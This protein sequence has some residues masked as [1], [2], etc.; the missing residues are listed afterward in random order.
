[1]TITFA[2]NVI[3]VTVYKLLFS[4]NVKRLFWSVASSFR[5]GYF[6]RLCLLQCLTYI[7]KDV[8]LLKMLSIHVSIHQNW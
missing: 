5:N 1:M 4:E 7:E 6:V 8:V 3:F 2:V